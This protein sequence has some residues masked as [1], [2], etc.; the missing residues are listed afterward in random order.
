MIN[1]QELDFDT[2][3]G[4]PQRFQLT[5]DHD[6]NHI[7]EQEYELISTLREE[8]EQLE[9]YTDRFILAM[10]I[11]RKYEIDGAIEELQMY[12]DLLEELELPLANHGSNPVNMKEHL[13]DPGLFDSGDFL[14]KP[15]LCDNYGR[16]LIYKIMKK[17]VPAM[18]SIFR[19]LWFWHDIIEALP[20]SQIRNGF[21]VVTDLKGLGMKNWDF[22]SSGRKKQSKIMNNFPGRL[23]SFYVV[24]AGFVFRPLMAFC[25]VIFKAKIISRVSTIDTKVLKEHIPLENIPVKYGGEWEVDMKSQWLDVKLEEFEKRNAKK[26]RKRK[27]RRRRRKK[28]AASETESEVTDTEDVTDDI[29]S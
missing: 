2:F 25:K 27:R 7:F 8:M 26:K 23:R 14:Y 18:D 1:T 6:P 9:H 16:V 15:G 21:T 12:F 5:E 28:Q 10:L 24:N 22:S 19:T 13:I 17:Y 3:N 29:S 4:L 11:L 20:F